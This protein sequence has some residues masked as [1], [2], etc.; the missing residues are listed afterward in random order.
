MSKIILHPQNHKRAQ[1]R[2][3]M[4]YNS[5]SLSTFSN[6]YSYFLV[7]FFLVHCSRT[8]L[9]TGRARFHS[10][11]SMKQRW[12]A[13]IPNYHQPDTCRVKLCTLI[14]ALKT[15]QIWPWSSKAL[16]HMLYFKHV[17]NPIRVNKIQH[18]P[19]DWIS[20]YLGCGPDY[21]SDRLHNLGQITVFLCL[22]LLFCPLREFTMLHTISS[23]IKPLW[24]LLETALL[25]IMAGI[26]MY[27][28]LFSN[29]CHTL[30]TN[31]YPAKPPWW[32]PLPLGL[33]TQYWQTIPNTWHRS[34][35]AVV[36]QEYCWRVPAGMG[37]GSS[38]ARVVTS[39]GLVLPVPPTAHPLSPGSARSP[40]LP[41]HSH[42]SLPTLLPVLYPQK[43]ETAVL[44]KPVWSTQGEDGVVSQGAMHLH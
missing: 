40:A 7:K 3:R 38:R 22:Y 20:E 12:I 30:K 35:T 44:G 26:L 32:H 27:F 2:S 24:N 18:K 34:Y 5:W 1:N 28:S 33:L 23:K 14:P 16:K 21:V 13:V 17:S 29:A 25:H 4:F 42:V 15:Y 11:N 39:L 10:C 8:L 37:Q 36:E 9:E 6:F 19:L 31:A 43:E 41:G